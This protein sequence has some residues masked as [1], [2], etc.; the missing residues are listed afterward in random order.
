MNEFIDLQSQQPK[1]DGK[2]L[3]V[4]RGFTDLRFADY[5]NGH[6]FLRGISTNK[7]THW[8]E[9]PVYPKTMIIDTLMKKGLQSGLSNEDKRQLCELLKME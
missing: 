6:W 7:V 2:Y 1:Q 9:C 5:R 4:L 3:V 8:F